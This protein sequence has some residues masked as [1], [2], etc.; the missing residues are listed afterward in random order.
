M[1]G[2]WSLGDYFKQEQLPWVFEFLTSETEGLGLDA[3]RLYVTVFAGDA[4][5]G[6]PADEEAVGIWKR[7]FSGKGID[8]GSPPSA[9]KQTV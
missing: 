3:K 8:A 7:L 4:A 2:N 5:A 9:A 6:M 1:L